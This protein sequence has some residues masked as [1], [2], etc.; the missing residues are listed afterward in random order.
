MLMRNLF[1][2][3]MLLCHKRTQMLQSRYHE[4]LVNPHGTK[5]SVWSL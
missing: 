3:C 5:P 1:A 4:L 2:S